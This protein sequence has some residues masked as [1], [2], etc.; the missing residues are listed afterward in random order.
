MKTKHNSW[1]STIVAILLTAFLVV[2]SAGVLSI[3]LQE[4]KNTRLVYNSISTYAWAEW[5]QEYALLKIKNHDEWF[6]DSIV[7]GQDD[8]SM[9]LAADPDDVKPKDQ[10]IEY[11]MS[12]NSK[13]YSWMVPSW[14]FDIIP[15]FYDKGIMMQHNSKNPTLTGA[16]MK[17]SNFKLVW[18]WAFVWNIIWNDPTWETFWI[19]WTWTTWVSIWGWYTVSSENWKIKK[20]EDDEG[21]AWAKKITFEQ[22]KIKDFIDAYDHNY[23]ILYNPTKNELSYTIESMEWFSTPK[24]SII[25]SSRI[26]N[27]K[28]NVLFE[29]NKNRYFEALKYS[30]INK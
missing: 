21:I 6:Q 8:D 19:T 12:T 27:F 1:F 5:A 18:S 4:S 25:A 22:I 13:N 23:L 30:I 7:D 24:T 10:H 15:L 28:Q 3:V 11:T 16:I 17:S 14:E 29:E 2:V 9:L 20:V 26:G